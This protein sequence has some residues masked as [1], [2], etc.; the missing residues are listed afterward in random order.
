MIKVREILAKARSN[1]HTPT[2]TTP[3][4]QTTSSSCART[5]RRNGRRPKKVM[6]ATYVVERMA[7][8]GALRKRTLVSSYGNERRRNKSKDRT[9]ARLS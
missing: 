9:Q 3:I 8:S 6:D 1:R 7:M 2:N 4:S 5:T